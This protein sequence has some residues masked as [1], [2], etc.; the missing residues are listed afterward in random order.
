MVAGLL[1]D[2][3]TGVYGAA[4][5]QLLAIS[6]IHIMKRESYCIEPVL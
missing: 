3:D 6:S 1:H 5:H 2:E 4:L